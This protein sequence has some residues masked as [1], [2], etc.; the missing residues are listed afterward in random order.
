MVPPLLTWAD[1]QQQHVVQWLLH[2]QYGR[3]LRAAV[4]G[5]RGARRA[6]GRGP[7][8]VRCKVGGVLLGWVFRGQR[9]LLHPAPPKQVVDA[10]TR[11]LAVFAGSRGAAAML[12]AQLLH[13]A[14]QLLEVADHLGVLGRAAGSCA[15]STHMGRIFL[16][17]RLYPRRIR[18]VVESIAFLASALVHSLQPLRYYKHTCVLHTTAVEPKLLPRYRYKSRCRDELGMILASSWPVVTPDHATI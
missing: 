9:G 4:G 14:M 6:D 17:S 10:S 5:T 2:P 12:A 18:V 15:G 7:V 11:V 1:V 3:L 16:V 13:I 8:A